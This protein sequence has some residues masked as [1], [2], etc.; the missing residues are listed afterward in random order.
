MTHSLSAEIKNHVVVF[1]DRSHIYITE[2]AY[3]Q[4]LE[5]SVTHSMVSVNGGTYKVS[6]IA[7]M[8]PYAS[9][10]KEYPDIVAKER[11]VE[12]PYYPPIETAKVVNNKNFK[13]DLLKG[14]ENYIANNETTGKAEALLESIKSGKKLNLVKTV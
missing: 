8:I 7:K 6:Q 4:I 2:K 3:K 14:L 11:S 5:K 12:R 9:F 13:A 10:Q 1:V